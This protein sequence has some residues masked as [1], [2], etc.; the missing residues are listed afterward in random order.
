M[1]IRL[2]LLAAV[3]GSALGPAFA[4]RPLQTEDAGILDRGQCEVEAAAER[5]KEPGGPTASGQGLQLACGVGRV[6]QVALAASHAKTDGLTVQGLRLGGKSELWRGGNDD[7]TAFAIAWGLTGGKAAGQSWEHAETDF[8][9][10]LSVALA[11]AT[12]HANLGHLRDEAGHGRSTTW[13]LAWEHAGLGAWA[14]M[15]E[16]FGDDRA[17]PWWNLG[18]R[19]TARPEQLFLDLSYGRQMAGGRPSLLTLGL[20]ATF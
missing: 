3:L 5:L 4:G 14:P 1:N 10:V 18:L 15:A 20:K 9:A 12:L 11:G 16:L 8:N 13:G 7:G 2:P 19:F 17:A 6:G